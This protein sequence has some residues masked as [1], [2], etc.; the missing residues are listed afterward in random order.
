MPF[1]RTK[2]RDGKKYRYLAENYWDKEK[3][4]SRQ[5]VIQ[6]LGVNIGEEGSEKFVPPSHKMDDIERAIPVGKFHAC[7][8][9]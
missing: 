9:K 8:V 1:I 2:I 4:S 5:R 7:S 6:Y 3:K